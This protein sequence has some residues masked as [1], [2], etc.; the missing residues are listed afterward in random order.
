MLTPKER[1]TR[2]FH[3]L[4]PDR[5]PFVPVVYEHAAKLINTM[6]S[7]L[8]CNEDLIVEGQLEAYKRYGMDIISIG[9]DIYNV[10]AEALGCKIK[11]FTENEPT[12]PGVIS[13]ILKEDKNKLKELN[14]PDP[15]RE[16]RMPLFIS[17]CERIIKEVGDE[18]QVNATIVGPF[19]LAA[20][21]RGFENFILDILMDPTYA[22]SLMD[23]T[24]LVGLTYG[25]AFAKIGTGLSINESWITPPLLSPELFRDFP[26]PYEKNLVAQL[27]KAGF[28]SVGLISGGNTWPIAPYLV[29]T[30]T[31]ILMADA[32]TDQAAYKKLSQEAGV[33]LRASIDAKLL[34]L[35]TDREIED[36]ALK[37]LR[38]CAPGGRFI[39]GCGVVPY[40]ADAKKV[41]KLKEVAL[42]FQDF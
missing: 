25:S 5:V 8:A 31:S 9:V 28:T 34:H 17:A 21:L 33:I 30:G 18:V 22:R 40:E 15:F 3:G 1:M 27:K 13:Q 29:Q 11:Y 12:V 32:I 37:V 19:T 36:A 16:G 20:I 39:L 23:F 35:G 14:V 7:I 4:R 41:L 10:E 6:P 26:F 2:V 24:S 42:G 38:T